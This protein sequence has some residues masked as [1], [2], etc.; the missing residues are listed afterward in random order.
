MQD[1]GIG[2]RLIHELQK[3]TLYPGIELLEVGTSVF[4]LPPPIDSQ[5]KLL[6]ADALT[7]G[8]KPAMIYTYWASELLQL[9]E[10]GA[11]RGFS[12][13]DFQLLDLLHMTEPPWP[14]DN[15]RIFGVEPAVIDFGCHLSPILKRA[16][17]RLKR[18]FK[19]ELKQIIQTINA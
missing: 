2:A 13:H 1:D 8:G 14:L 3:E 6:V 12:L 17:P 5:S 9:Q 19:D 16:L 7:A 11:E 4:F 15:C 10:A 18:A